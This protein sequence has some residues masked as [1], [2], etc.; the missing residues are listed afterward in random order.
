LT[1]CPDTGGP[2]QPHASFETPAARAPQDEGASSMPSTR[3]PHAE[4]RPRLMTGQGGPSGS[5]GASRS[6][7]VV[8]AARLPIYPA[9]ELWGATPRYLYWCRTL[10]SGCLSS[11]LIWKTLTSRLVMSPLSSKLTTPCSVLVLEVW[12]ASR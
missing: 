5:A 10:S 11:R 1:R 2:D 6:T 9:H 7:L 12:I 4:E 3:L 8:N